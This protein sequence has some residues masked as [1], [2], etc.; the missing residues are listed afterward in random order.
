VNDRD[1]YKWR[2]LGLFGVYRSRL[3]QTV[4]CLTVVVADS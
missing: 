2:T 1:P 4:I 3:W